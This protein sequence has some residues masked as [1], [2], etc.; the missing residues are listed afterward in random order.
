MKKKLIL[1]LTNLV[2]TVGAISLVLVNGK[3]ETD[4]VKAKEEPYTLNLSNLSSSNTT[5]TTSNGNSIEFEVSGY[6]DGTFSNNSY[7]RNTTPIN[8]IESLT[9]SFETLNSDLTISY[10]WYD[11]DYYVTDGVI[12]SNNLAYTFNNQYPSYFKLEN[13]SGGE[14]DVTSIQ[15]EYSCSE[16]SAP[17]AYSN[18][19]YTLSDDGKSYSASKLNTSITSAI[20]LSEYNGKPVTSISENAFQD[21]LSLTSIVI[22]SGVTTIGKYAFDY[23]FSLVSI[24]IPDSVTSIGKCA[25][26]Y[27][28]SLTSIA[29]PDSI[30]VIGDSAFGACSSLQYNEY[31]NAY[32]LGNSLNPYVVLMKAKDKS[33]TSCNINGNCKVISYSAF[34]ACSSLTSITIPDSVTSIGECAFRYCSSLHSIVIPNSVTSIGDSAFRYCSLLSTLT[35]GNGITSIGEYAFAKCSSLG[36]S[37]T[38]V[39]IPSSVTSIGRQAFS[40]CSLKLTIYCRAKSK[41]SGWSSDW[42]YSSSD[43]YYI[44]VVW[45]YTA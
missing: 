17:E 37:L 3:Y 4:Y 13:E 33:I 10:G 35:L 2:L 32:Y 25:F 11:N 44:S 42:N 43:G 9:I 45:N 26:S 38:R 8:G 19:K 12:N 15:L 30:T 41:P 28:S 6:S 7:I 23:C 16:S 24:T 39:V 1:I 40:D 27:C 31:D 29:I 21:C 34:D 14:I 20:V 18:V 36:S 5:L 22:P